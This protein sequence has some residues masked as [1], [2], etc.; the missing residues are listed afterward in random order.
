[1]SIIDT[2]GTGQEAPPNAV[3]G[4]IANTPEDAASDLFVIIPSFAVRE[5]WGPCRFAPK[6]G[7]LPVRD[8]PCLVIFDDAGDPWVA[9]WWN[10]DPNTGGGGG[11]EVEEWLS[12]TG[13]PASALGNTGDWYLDTATGTV[14]EKTAA[15]TWT[16]RTDLTGPQ[17]P[18]GVPG[19]TG[20]QGPPGPTG[21]TGAQGIQGP[22]GPAGPTGAPG[23]P[24][25]EVWQGINAP[26]PRGDYTVWIDT[27]EP[28]PAPVTPPLVTTLP[29]TP[30][31]GQEVY[32]R[33]AW[34]SVGGSWQPSE[35]HLR[36]AADWFA[37]DGCGW[38]FVG[39]ANL[40]SEGQGLVQLAANNTW[41]TFDAANLWIDLPLGGHYEIEYGAVVAN[42]VAGT[43]IYSRAIVAALAATDSFHTSAV[44]TAYGGQTRAMPVANCAAGARVLFQHLAATGTNSSYRRTL[45]ATPIRLRAT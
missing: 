12:G 5:L 45:R 13:A 10:G 31:N 20:A 30:Y 21:A 41:Q 26:A 33:P 37:A 27:D 39:G 34:G 16:Y 15:A 6:A 44:A 24:T 14:Y 43:V 22:T 35:W 9:V 25:L 8:D 23:P 40:F 17:G 29:A 18:Q 32:Y 11:T 7:Q 19:S 36:Y 3:E 1:M 4:R 28:D 42:S 2:F 38:V